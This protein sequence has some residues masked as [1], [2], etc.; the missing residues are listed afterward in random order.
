MSEEKNDAFLTVMLV[1][2]YLALAFLFLWP[3]AWAVEVIF[4]RLIPWVEITGNQSLYIAAA[5]TA[6]SSMSPSESALKT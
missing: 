3:N 4:S 1:P 2:A 5:L 6:F